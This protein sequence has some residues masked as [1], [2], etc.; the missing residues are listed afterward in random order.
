M[1]LSGLRAHRELADHLLAELKSRPSHAYL[2]SGP[3]GTGKA[4]VATALAHAML[5]E[6]APGA[7]FCCTIEHCPVRMAPAPSG[8]ARAASLATPRCGC[9]AACVQIA[10]GSHPDFLRIARAQGKTEVSIDQVRT[11]I[12]ELGTKP[13]RGA[14]R[15]A[16]IDD[17]ETLNRPA[18]NALLKVLEEPPGRAIIFVISA[19]EHALIDTVRSRLRPVRFGALTPADL[20]AILALHGAPEGANRAAAAR[21]AR[22]SA[23]RALAILAGDAPPMKE[24]LTAIAHAASLN[25]AGASSLAQQY[26]KTRD[27]AAANF[28]LI[29]RML[30]E[31]LLERLLGADEAP[32]T[33]AS[34]AESAM[35]AKLA[36]TMATGAIVDSMAAAVA[37]R[38]AVD[39]MANPRM[40]AEQFWMA[41]AAAMRGRAE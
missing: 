12:A 19:A 23:A 1:P 8:R 22:G 36:A 33:E 15:I 27:E 2:F 31:I 30:E 38:S 9:C 14:V 35:V 37:A 41:A 32:K 24:L 20:E 3:A 10:S 29:A 40:Q 11:L 34:S 4:L 5:C 18:Q 13:S 39:A 28:E 7:D 16:I 6:R 25:F 21:L 17:A 26:F